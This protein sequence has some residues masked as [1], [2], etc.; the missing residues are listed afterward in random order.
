MQAMELVA[1]LL[2]RLLKAKRM[3][4]GREWRRALRLDVKMAKM[5]VERKHG[6]Q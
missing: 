1:H 2:L 4:Q 5:V 6:S 3:L